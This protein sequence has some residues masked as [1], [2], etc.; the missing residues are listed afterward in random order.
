MVEE[1]RTRRDA[2]AS[3]LDMLAESLVFYAGDPSAK[4]RVAQQ[5]THAARILSALYRDASPRAQLLLI[6]IFL[7]SPQPVLRLFADD[8]RRVE[9][10][11][12]GTRARKDLR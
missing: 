6:T 9:V 2:A 8:L 3:A 11:R 10:A 1:S 5:R 12:R 7:R 4:K